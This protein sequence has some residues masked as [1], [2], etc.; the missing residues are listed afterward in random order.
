MGVASLNDYKLYI[1]LTDTQSFISKGIKL[2]TRREYSHVSISLDVDLEDLYSFG[3]LKP[4]NPLIGGFVK[5]AL[6]SGTY[7]LFPNTT[8]ALFSIDVT[9]QQFFD[10]KRIIQRFKHSD[11]KYRYNYIGVAGLMINKPINREFRYF[12]SQFVQEVLHKSG[13]NIIN[14]DKGLT[15]PEDFINNK[16]LELIYEG[17]LHQYGIRM[18]N[19]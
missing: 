10:A 17:R 9:S 6:D 12:C 14:K 5:E 3:R 4:H 19:A 16:E 11:Q 18:K 2:Y 13:V 1:L 7:T 15:L 8:C